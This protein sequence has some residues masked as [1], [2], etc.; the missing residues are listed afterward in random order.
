M[1]TA[2]RQ[3]CLTYGGSGVLIERGRRL[4]NQEQ[5]AVLKEGA[6][7]P[8][9][10]ALPLRKRLPAFPKKRVESLRGAG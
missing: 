7:K 9:A 4:I 5:R 6:R 3:E 2:Q 8:Q 10:F 1:C